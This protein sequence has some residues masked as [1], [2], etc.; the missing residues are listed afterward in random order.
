MGESAPKQM[1]EHDWRRHSGSVSCIHMH[2]CMY[3]HTCAQIV[4]VEQTTVLWGNTTMWNSF[5]PDVYD[6][7]YL[8]PLF[9]GPVLMPHHPSFLPSRFKLSWSCA[10]VF[11]ESLME[12]TCFKLYLIKQRTNQTPAQGQ[13]FIGTA[14]PGY[15]RVLEPVS[16]RYLS[17]PGSTSKMCAHPPALYFS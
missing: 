15:F 3:T 16:A 5:N 4:R 7:L 6:I 14:T 1:M 9:L 10:T 2:A 13:P 17:K 8:R 11:L 12:P